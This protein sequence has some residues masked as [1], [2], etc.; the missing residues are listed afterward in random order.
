MST[1]EKHCTACG[2]PGDALRV[3]TLL[4]PSPHPSSLQ[5]SMPSTASTLVRISCGIIND[6]PNRHK[7]MT[8][9]FEKYNMTY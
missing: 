3:R 8:K 5:A 2:S 7:P 1:F 6:F 4:R 9:Y